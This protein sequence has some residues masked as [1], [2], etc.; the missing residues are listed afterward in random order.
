MRI[1]IS[2]EEPWGHRD[3][4][5]TNK[6][7]TS[8]SANMRKTTENSDWEHP[9]GHNSQGIHIGKKRNRLSQ[10]GLRGCDD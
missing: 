4:D 2:H 1:N 6:Q 5:V 8:L 10:W 3:T 9:V 7:G